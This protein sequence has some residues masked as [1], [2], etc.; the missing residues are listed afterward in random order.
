MPPLLLIP[1]IEDVFENECEG[2]GWVAGDAIEG[3]LHYAGMAG[4]DEFI[5][6]GGDGFGAGG[7]GGN[8]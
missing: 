6:S 1:A 7:K 4:E 3:V 8:E 2:I 5:G